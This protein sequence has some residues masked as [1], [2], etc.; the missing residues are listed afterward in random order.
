M[1]GASAAIAILACFAVAAALQDV[2]PFAGL[3]PAEKG[4]ALQ[5]FLLLRAAPLYLIAVLIEQ[6]ARVEQSLGESERRYREV[7]ESQTGFVCR[8]LPDTTLTF[9]NEAYCRSVGRDREKLINTRLLDLLPEETRATARQQMELAA[10]SGEPCE[11]EH[12][13]KLADGRSGWQHWAVH[14]IYNAAGQLRRI[15]GDWSGHHGSQEGRG[16]QSQSRPRGA[17]RNGRRA[18]RDG[19]A[20][21]ESAAVGDSQ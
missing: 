19:R 21:S 11:W 6:K 12:E 18:D 20:R 10:S 17:A 14:A 16:G 2:G 15:P 9:V 7:V 8:F 5:R 4:I 1:R 3:S 13:V